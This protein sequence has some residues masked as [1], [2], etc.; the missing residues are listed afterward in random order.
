MDILGTFMEWWITAELL[1]LTSVAADAFLYRTLRRLV[2]AH[3]H[4]S[5]CFRMDIN[6]SSWPLLKDNTSVCLS[7]S[8]RDKESDRMCVQM[9]PYKPFSDSFSEVVMVSEWAAVIYAQHQEKHG[10]TDRQIPVWQEK[11]VY[12]SESNTN[13]CTQRHTDTPEGVTDK[14]L[15]SFLPAGFPQLCWS[16]RAHET[17]VPGSLTSSKQ[18]SIRDKWLNVLTENNRWEQ[19][20]I[21]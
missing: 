11:E 6:A 9:S 2:C 14:S 5:S 17:E 10:A 19:N 20:K 16:R 7:A 18:L 3:F 4:Q 21:E 12:S 15:S 13:R 8:S 1:Q